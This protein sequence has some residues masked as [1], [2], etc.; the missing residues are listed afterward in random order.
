MHVTQPVVVAGHLCLDL[1]PRLPG[2]PNIEPGR[3]VDVGPLGVSPGGC[4]G[5]TGATLAA[6]GVPARLAASIGTDPLGSLLRSLLER[7]LLDVSGVVAREHTETSYS[8]VVEAPGTDRTF[9]H[10]VGA[11]ASFDGA[12]V[13]VADAAVLHVGYPTHL[14]ALIRDDARPL[15]DLLTRAHGAGAVTSLDFAEIDPRSSAASLPWESILR[16]V[17]PLVDVVSPSVDDLRSMLPRH[18]L[19]QAGWAELLVSWG[20]GVAMVSAGADGICV[21][22]GT[23]DRLARTGRLLAGACD[24]WADV[25]LAVPAEPVTAT[26]TTGA[27][28]A[29]SAGF[30]A[31]IVAGQSCADAAARAVRTAAA[32]LRGAASVQMWRDRRC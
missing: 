31:A 26:A 17:L 13:R 3:L 24:A 6:L 1:T 20:A 28:D 25:R 5:N 21:G 9:W 14:P 22:T 27:G 32:R 16:R 23:R 2:P 19:S 18:E 11:N 30:I 29:A 12:D 10:H 15:V 8:I 4:V 7:P